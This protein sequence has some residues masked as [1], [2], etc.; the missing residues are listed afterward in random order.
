MPPEGDEVLNAVRRAYLPLLAVLTLMVAVHVQATVPGSAVEAGLPEGVDGAR[1]EEPVQDAAD[2]CASGCQ[3]GPAAPPSAGATVEDAE[4]P[5]PTP[6]SSAADPWVRFATKTVYRFTAHSM[7]GPAHAD[8]NA[9]SEEI[10]PEVPLE[11]DAEPA[12]PDAEP[13]QP[14]E[15]D[16]AEGQP[17]PL[18]DLRPQPHA[19]KD[20]PVEQQPPEPRPSLE[21]SPPR[22]SGP[23]ASVTEAPGTGQTLTAV[24]V[25]VLLAI[26]AGLAALLAYGPLRG[27]PLLSLFSHVPRDSALQHPSR[28]RIH[29][30]VSEQPGI[31]VADVCRLADLSRSTVDYHLDIL[32]RHDLLALRR[33]GKLHHIYARD[34]N[35]D[36]GEKQAYAAL[37]NARCRRIASFVDANPG[38]NQSAIS[39]ALAI[40]RSRAY[41]FLRGLQESGILEARRQGREVQYFPTGVSVG[42]THR[43]R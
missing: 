38:S 6:G 40:P 29:E 21:P 9:P 5:E 22:P 15:G 2:A 17:E 19:Q 20:E 10:V 39:N 32:V 7:D 14:P 41:E 36:R 37:R 42:F 11:P 25:A 12:E 24:Q 34:Q 3:T 4:D 31:C 13:S 16:A 23:R 26:P 33:E 43:D 18:L 8:S 1:H 35:L 27:A 30:I 28:R